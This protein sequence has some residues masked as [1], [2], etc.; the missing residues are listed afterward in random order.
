MGICFI[1]TSQDIKGINP[2]CHSNADLGVFFNVRN[3]RD[4]EAMRKK[5]C[6]F[7]K[8]ND[9]MEEVTNTVLQQKWHTMIFDQSEPSR[10]PQYTMFCG[11][12]AEPPPF[13]MGAKALW[14]LNKKQLQAIVNENPELNYLLETDNWGI[15]GEEEFNR[16]RGAF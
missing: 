9:E 5:F 15:L 4:K 1:V 7:F 3:E 16:M 14:N 2:A 12:A 8:N 6:D 11:R 10:P 13:V